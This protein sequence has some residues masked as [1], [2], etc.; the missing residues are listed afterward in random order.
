[1]CC[2]ALRAATLL[3]CV[4]IGLSLDPSPK[5]AILIEGQRRVVIQGSEVFT[6]IFRPIRCLSL[7]QYIEHLALL[8]L[9]VL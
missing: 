6:E 9:H 3:L 4:G 7:L 8:I 5:T 1:M 2:G